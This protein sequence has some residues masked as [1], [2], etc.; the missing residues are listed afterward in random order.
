MPTRMHSQDPVHQDGHRNDVER[1]IRGI[2]R[3]KLTETQYRRVA[4]LYGFDGPEMGVR[5]V[6]RAEGRDK[7]AIQKSRDAML[8]KLAN[9]WRLWGLWLLQDVRVPDSDRV[10]DGVWDAEDDIGGTVELRPSGTRWESDGYRSNPGQT[11]RH[12]PPPSLEMEC[13]AN[14]WLAYNE[15]LTLQQNPYAGHLAERWATGWSEARI[16]AEL[17]A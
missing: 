13:E 1:A 14:G 9:D 8:R 4:L 2:L 6:A 15:G 12:V 16:T 17:V 10:E 3:E 5:E 11:S 7:V